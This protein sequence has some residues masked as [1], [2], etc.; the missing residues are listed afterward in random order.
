MITTILALLNQILV[1]PRVLTKTKEYENVAEKKTATNINKC[2]ENCVYGRQQDKN[3]KKKTTR[4]K[5]VLCIV[6][7]YIVDTRNKT[8]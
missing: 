3:E 4:M 1:C 2:G 6:Y 7:I 8:K 5:N